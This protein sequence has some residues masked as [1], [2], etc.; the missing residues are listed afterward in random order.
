M[1][2][3]DD[4]DNTFWHIRLSGGI[5]VAPIQFG[6]VGDWHTPGDFTG[7]GRADLVVVRDLEDGT[8][9]WFF[10]AIQ[11]GVVSGPAQLL[12]FSQ[13]DFGNGDTPFLDQE[14]Q[15]DYTG[16]GRTDVAVWRR[17]APG[18]LFIRNSATGV[19]TDQAFG[20]NGDVRAPGVHQLPAEH[21]PLR[22]LT[23]L[24]L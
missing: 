19:V 4:D 2:R 15:A 22:R 5:F 16:D 17:G 10:L 20:Q 8:L 18:H 3:A 9:R 23:R 24:R 13:I 21:L 7:D 6:T 14:V 11:P 1:R 12:G